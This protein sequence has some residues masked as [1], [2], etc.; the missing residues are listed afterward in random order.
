MSEK[1][2]NKKTADDKTRSGK[3]KTP[4]RRLWI[5][6]L[7]FL[8]GIAI[9]GFS[10]FK[11][12]FD[13]PRRHYPKKE[14]RIGDLIRK[15]EPYQMA[16][17]AI[18]KDPLVKEKLGPAVVPNGDPDG[19]LYETECTLEFRLI[20]SKG[21]AHVSGE[22]RKVSSKWV[23]VKLDVDLFGKGV[24]VLEMDPAP[25]GNKPPIWRSSMKSEVQELN[26]QPDY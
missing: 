11:K 21:Q 22:A 8:V 7:V 20:G 10:V 16:L 2:Q 26:Y 18:I 3:S 6:I 24:I 5:P 23:F 17:E 15:S 14:V 25:G 9:V 19:N 13:R 4:R 1:S 12:E